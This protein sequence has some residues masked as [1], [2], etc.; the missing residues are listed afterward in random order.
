MEKPRGYSLVD[1]LRVYSFRWMYW[2]GS[3]GRLESCGCILEAC[4]EGGRVTLRAYCSGEPGCD[5][6]K[7]GIGALGVMEDVSP[8]LGLARGDPI[9]GGV[10]EAMP[11]YRLRSTSPWAAFLIA[12]CQ[13]NASF[14]MG[15]RMLLRLHLSAGE[16]L[17]LPD[18]SVYIAT[19][20]P[21]KL[22]EN[23]LREARVGYRARTILEAAKLALEGCSDVDVLGGVRG[24]GPYT[25]S[26]VRLLACRDYTALPLDRWLAKLASEAYRVDPRGVEGEI[27]RRFDGWTGL[28]A[29]QATIA[30]DAQPLRRALERLRRGLNRPGL[31]EPSPV[32]LWKWSDPDNPRL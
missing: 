14:R 5:P 8:Y 12:V 23:V 31:D 17:R 13:Q 20:R 6:L 21:E 27:R 18:G 22:D 15:W 16:R 11:G 9:V 2:G 29:I 3:C 1:T 32:T 25:L 24:V 4:E 19:P 10:V 26:L 30:F 7:A 28:Y